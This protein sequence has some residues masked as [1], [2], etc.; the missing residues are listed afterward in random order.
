MSP[1]SGL[2]IRNVE[3]MFYITGRCSRIKWKTRDESLFFKHVSTHTDV[4][5]L[6]DLFFLSLSC[7]LMLQF[8]KF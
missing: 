2:E 4:F 7:M 5:L 8:N 6:L 3:I 1:S